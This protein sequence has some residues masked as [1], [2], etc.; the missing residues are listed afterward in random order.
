ML[1]KSVDLETGLL[2]L[3]S[4]PFKQIIGKNLLFILLNLKY[5]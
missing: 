3:F 4:S 1:R 5:F 2:V